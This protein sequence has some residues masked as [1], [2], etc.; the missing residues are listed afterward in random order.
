MSIGPALFVLPID[1]HILDTDQANLVTE[2][3][4]SSSTPSIM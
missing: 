2:V 1:G 4:S 3:G